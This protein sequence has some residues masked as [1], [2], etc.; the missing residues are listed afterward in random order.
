M[1]K[2]LQN[3]RIIFEPL[4]NFPLEKGETQRGLNL[5]IHK[6]SGR[7]IHLLRESILRKVKAD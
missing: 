4:F 7:Q 1:G 6:L 2:H 3:K 5:A